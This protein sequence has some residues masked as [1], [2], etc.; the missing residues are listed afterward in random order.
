MTTPPGRPPDANEQIR[1]RLEKLE[2]LAGARASTRSAQRFPVTHWG[3]HAA[4]ALQGRGRGRAA[5]ARARWRWPG[6]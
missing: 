5:A 1:R 6:G 3:G 2:A 4:G